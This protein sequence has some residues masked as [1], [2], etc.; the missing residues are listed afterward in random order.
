MNEISLC[1]FG[2]SALL[3]YLAW[4]ERAGANT[5]DARLLAGAAGFS[6]IAGAVA[7]AAAVAAVAE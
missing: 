1:I 2:F 6:G 5:R 4:R 3:L 7:A